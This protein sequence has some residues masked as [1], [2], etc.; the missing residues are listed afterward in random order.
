MRSADLQVR[1][2]SMSGPG[3]PRSRQSPDRILA[4]PRLID[5]DAPARPRGQYV[6][7]FVEH[8]RRVDDVVAPRH[9]VDVDLHD[10][11]VRHGRTE[12][13]ADGAGEMA[14]EIVRRD[15]DLIDV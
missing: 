11:E 2:M 1:I 4:Q 9:A 12:M 8:R 10:A 14:V 5:L 7:A 15:V 6:V 3:G 13:R